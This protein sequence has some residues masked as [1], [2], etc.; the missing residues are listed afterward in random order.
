MST[1]VAIISGANFSGEPKK[2]GRVSLESDGD[3]MRG[4]I[5]RHGVNYLSVEA[6]L[7]EDVPVNGLR[8]AIVFIS[9]LCIRRRPRPGV[10]S[11]SASRI[12]RTK[13]GCSGV[14]GKVVFKP[15]HHDPL[16]ELEIV[17]LRGAIYMEGDVVARRSG[18]ARSAK[19]FCRMRFRI[20]MIRAL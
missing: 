2:Q 13:V 10:R 7:T 11:G 6:R 14:G 5:E 8:P 19:K 4:G 18:S 16:T 1:D 20:S 9:S 17:E 12:S 15:S 3:V